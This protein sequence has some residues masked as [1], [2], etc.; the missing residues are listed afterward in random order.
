MKGHDKDLASRMQMTDV[1]T[2]TR[3]QLRQSII[4]KKGNYSI[5]FKQLNVIDDISFRDIDVKME[6]GEEIKFLYLIFLPF[7]IKEK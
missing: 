2:I 6:V 5:V 1:K 4:Y 3:E 7:Y